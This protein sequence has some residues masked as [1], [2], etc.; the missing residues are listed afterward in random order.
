[1]NWFMAAKIAWHL[2][3]RKIV[4]S[5]LRYA[6][7]DMAEKAVEVGDLAFKKPKG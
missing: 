1:M 5:L 6:D 2:G 7:T 4:K 3:G